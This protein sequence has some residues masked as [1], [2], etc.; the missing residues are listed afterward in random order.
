MSRSG[1]FCGCFA[2]LLLPSRGG[3]TIVHVVPPTWPPAVRWFY[4]TM[5]KAH[6]VEYKFQPRNQKCPTEEM[7]MHVSSCGSGWKAVPLVDTS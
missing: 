6:S 1:D 3:L 7:Q 5:L 4:E 2:F